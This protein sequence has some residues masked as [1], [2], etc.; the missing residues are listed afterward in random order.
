M[1]G[2]SQTQRSSCGLI[3]GM[4][5]QRTQISVN[6]MQ[7]AEHTLP[8]AGSA[9][10]R[11]ERGKH[12]SS[13][14][15][16]LR[17]PLILFSAL[18]VAA[19][20]L[21]FP[22]VWQGWVD[23]QYGKLVYSA[24]DVPNER[25]ALVLGARVYASGRLSGMLR[26][27]VETAVALYKAGKVE[28]LLMSGDNSSLEY[29]EPDAMMAHAVAMGVPAADI[30]PDYAGRRTYDSCYRARAIFEVEAAVIVTQAFHLPR[31]LFLCNQLGVQSVGV[32]A[33]QR[34]YDPR[35]IAWSE[36][37][38]IPATFFALLDVIRRGPP[39]VLGDPIPLSEP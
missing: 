16:L 36:G 33:D 19:A 20:G 17:R 13:W 2:R 31:A 38:E 8:T 7:S 37:R 12:P 18:L 15:H 25:V 23:S 30:Q 39:A 26:D 34:Q 3:A 22:F 21:S 6:P 35:S 1:W 9:A 32:A 4:N 24:A 5:T 28:K 29:N 11:A 27:R 14:N 10:N